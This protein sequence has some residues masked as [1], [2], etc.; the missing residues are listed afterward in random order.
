MNRKIKLIVFLVMLYTI[1]FNI[2]AYSGNIVYTKGGYIA[3]ITE[4]L[5]DKAI[6]LSVAGDDIALQKLLNT[7]LVIVLKEGIKVEIIDTKF[8]S[9]K[10]KIRPYGTNIELWT[11]VEA[12]LNN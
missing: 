12:I 1:F 4:E 6:R 11:V 7:N 2:T 3:A 9:G 10:A 8:F 5:S